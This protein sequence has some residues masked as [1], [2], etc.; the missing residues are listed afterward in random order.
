M[1]RPPFRS[2]VLSSS[3][4]FQCIYT[5]DVTRLIIKPPD[6]NACTRAHHHH[7]HH[8]HILSRHRLQRQYVFVVVFVLPSG[9][10]KNDDTGRFMGHLQ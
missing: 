2:L 4:S 8:H 7:H 6:H 9:V 3:R 1:T 10:I 5:L